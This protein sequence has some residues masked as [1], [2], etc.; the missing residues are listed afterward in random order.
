[1]DRVRADLS[2]TQKKRMKNA[3]EWGA[4]D[5][6]LRAEIDAHQTAMVEFQAATDRHQLDVQDLM[7]QK[8]LFDS[9]AKE[10]E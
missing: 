8:E 1:M 3:K 6:A 4:V 10:Y 5:E 2:V 9:K 7:G